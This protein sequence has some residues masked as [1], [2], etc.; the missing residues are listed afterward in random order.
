MDGLER[1][2]RL[3]S[4]RISAGYSQVDNSGSSI[5]L[6]F[7]GRSDGAFYRAHSIFPP[8]Y[9]ISILLGEISVKQIRNMI[10]DAR[11]LHNPANI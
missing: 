9:L 5:G 6:V 2:K 3:E 10:K 11:T 1:M 7:D 4:I 8:D